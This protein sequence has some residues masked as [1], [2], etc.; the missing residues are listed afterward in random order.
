[1]SLNFNFPTSERGTIDT[2]P[3]DYYTDSMTEAPQ[4]EQISQEM[5]PMSPTISVNWPLPAF[6]YPFR[7][8]GTYRTKRNHGHKHFQLF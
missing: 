5:H 3:L 7:P 1:M 2:P 8:T 6:P 4:L